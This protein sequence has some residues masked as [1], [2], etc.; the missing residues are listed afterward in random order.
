MRLLL[1]LAAGLLAAPVAAQEMVTLQTRP[2]VSQS[3]FIAG[4]GGRKPEAV[5]LL[6]AGGDGRIN[7]RLEDGKPRFN[8]GNFL[9]RSRLEFIRNGI[10]PVI[11]DAPGDQQGPDGMTDA[12]RESPQHSLDVLAVVNE[13]KRRYPGLPVF[14]VGTSRGTVSVANL[15]RYLKTEVSGLV[16]TSTLFHLA[17]GLQRPRPVLA[18]FNWM[19]LPVPLLFVHHADDACPS[20]PVADAIRL[21]RSYPLIIVKGG[22][23]AESGP[24]DPRSAHG[25]F[26]KEPETVAAL[27]AW[28]LGKPFQ[29]EI[30]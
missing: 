27:S 1:L 8:P 26:G 2:G 4:M 7:L 21:A 10:V 18:G 15:G 3:F 17:G 13:M 25:F 29:R 19:Q 20:T 6:F 9:P 28:M 30:N 5:A 12:F 16:L 11:L 23:P 24:C 14:L 22:K